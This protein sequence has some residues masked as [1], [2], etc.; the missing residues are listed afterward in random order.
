[1]TPDAARAVAAIEQHGVLL[2]QDPQLP[3]LAVLIAGEPIR[4][5]WWGHPAG[6]RIFNTQGD[7]TDH[8]DVATFK[9]VDRKVCFV[10]RRLWPAIVA[11]GQAREAWQLAG[12]SAEALDLLDRVDTHG[13]VRATKQPAKQIETRLLAASE[14]VHT[15]SGAHATEL[16]RWD[17]FAAEHEVAALPAV[18][19]AKRQLEDAVAKLAAPTRATPRLPWQFGRGRRQPGSI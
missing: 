9:L 8:D 3:S 11:V 13:R 19:E 1:M 14:E 12:L 18:E 15:E 17:I 16:V 10:Q 2:L 6:N 4:G 7:L 5:S